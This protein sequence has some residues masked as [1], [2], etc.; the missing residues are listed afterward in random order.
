MSSLTRFLKKICVQDAVY[1]GK[2]VSNGAD[3]VYSQPKLIK[4]RWEE[5]TETVIDTAGQIVLSK[6]KILVTEDLEIGGLLYLGDFNALTNEHRIDPQS[7]DGVYTI[8]RVEKIPFIG[9]DS[10]WVRTVWLG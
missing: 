6:A 3:L 7:L 9:S 1:W 2:P 8:K 4:C 5:R 10:E